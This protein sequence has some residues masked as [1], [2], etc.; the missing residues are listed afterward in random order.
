MNS[1]IYD[2]PV[3]AE[4]H[5]V[6]EALLDQ[7]GGDLAEYRRRTRERQAAS[8]RNVVTAPLNSRVAPS[9]ACDGTNVSRNR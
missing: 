4:V 3:V 8:S 2:D 9:N 6:R 5:A 7:C 1:P